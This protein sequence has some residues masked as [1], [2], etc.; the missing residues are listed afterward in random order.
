M[1]LFRFIYRACK[2]ATLQ[3]LFFAWLLICSLIRFKNL[4]FV[5]SILYD[6][7]QEAGRSQIDGHQHVPVFIAGKV[8]I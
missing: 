7:I 4:T 5:E 6:S 1:T 2:V 8:V 3:A